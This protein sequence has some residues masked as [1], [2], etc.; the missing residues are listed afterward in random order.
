MRALVATRPEKGAPVAGSQTPAYLRIAAEWAERIDSGALRHGDQLPTRAELGEQYGVSKTVIRDALG[1]LHQDGYLSS[2]GRNGTAVFRLKRY[3]L[4][5]AVLEADDRGRDA[6]D[7]AVKTQGGEPYQ[8]IRVE[9]IVP[10]PAIQEALGLAPDELALARLRR[11]DIDGTPY[12]I[13]DSF[14]PYKLVKGTPIA[15]P[16]DIKRGGRHVLRE[17]GHEMVRHHDRIRS[18]RARP[19]EIAELGIPEGLSV[20]R[21]LR[22][23]YDAAGTP[24]RHMASTYP[25]DRWEL[26][27]E[28]AK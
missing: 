22:T 16:A 24:I 25:S 11:R 26:I 23:S 19:R 18:R 21:H 9:T 10:D 17:I 1:L 4:P 28:V 14:F 7:D 8:N 3:E 6:F 20:I 15:E 27:Y 2:N 5:L 12:C 13:T